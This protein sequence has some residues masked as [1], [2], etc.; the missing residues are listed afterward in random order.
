M[1]DQEGHDFALAVTAARRLLE[2]DR[3]SL[4]G[5]PFD[6]VPWLGWSADRLLLSAEPGLGGF[7]PT[8]D[9]LWSG[10][11]PDALRARVGTAALDWAG[12]T[13]AMVRLPLPPGR[14]T[15]ELIHE[16]FHVVQ[17]QL[18]PG[19]T[20]REDGPGR[21]LLDTPDG[22]VWLGL[23][24]RALAEALSTD[25]DRRRHAAAAALSFRRRRYD[26]AVV[27]ERQRETRLDVVEGTAEYTGWR[28]TGAS[29]ADVADHVSGPRPPSWSR[30]FPYRTGP[31][32]GF[33]L[34]DLAPDWRTAM[35]SH[36]DLQLLLA[37]ALGAPDLD[38][39]QEAGR[40]GLDKLRDEEASR[41]GEV[42][43]LAERFGVPRRLRIVRPREGLQ[44]LFNPQRV[45]ATPAGTIYQDFVWRS[46]DGA[47]L[48][49]P[50]GAVI[51]EN[52]D[53]LQVPLG[54]TVVQSGLTSGPGWTLVLPEAWAIREEGACV[55]V[56]APS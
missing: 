40:Y 1:Q 26:L 8:T 41:Q 39:D 47:R 2:V 50:E 25:D 21:E 13:W 30:A 34:D 18:F 14:E 56:S 29:D 10:H 55:V 9:G 19:V 51:S 45:W 28:L 52:W 6:A 3:G 27:E 46:D 33:L 24:V 11:L 36:P 7:E 53:E 38:P 5:V 4:W 20:L 31:A 35:R 12:R 49:A 37:R 44:V 42:A 32:Y 17:P 54:D 23:E 15:L 48:E 22:R 16:A 43:K